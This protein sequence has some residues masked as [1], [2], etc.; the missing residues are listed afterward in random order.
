MKFL[1]YIKQAIQITLL[2][3]KT[4]RQV[5]QDKN[6]TV[7]AIILSVLGLL[8]YSYVPFARQTSF[9]AIFL[10][11]LLSVLV[12]AIFMGLTHALARGFGSKNKFM[13]FFRPIM[14]FS[15]FDLVYLL[16]LIPQLSI[17]VTIIFLIWGLVVTFVVIKETYHLSN[18]RTIGVLLLSLLIGI[19]ITTILI[20]FFGGLLIVAKNLGLYL[21]N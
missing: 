20:A 15:L 17:F 12:T 4:I 6:A 14:L 11:F 3:K 10:N 2:N 21:P 16:V 13:H 7:P 5:A 9:L 8:V 18:G 1:H 19:I